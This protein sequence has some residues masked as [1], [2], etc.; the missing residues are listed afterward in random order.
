MID[1][2]SVASP[3]FA[4]LGVA[5]VLATGRWGI[6]IDRSVSKNLAASELLFERVR[7]LADLGEAR[8]E[9]LEARVDQLERTV[10]LNGRSR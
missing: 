1:L 5:A 9:G 6:K 10:A 8:H 4:A 2:G 3:F 7:G